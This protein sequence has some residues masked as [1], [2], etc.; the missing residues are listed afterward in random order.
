VANLCAHNASTTLWARRS[1]VV[2]G[3]NTSRENPRYLPGFELHQDL[4]ATD[5][6]D[7]AIASADVLVLGVASAGFPDTL[8][9][10]DASVRPGTP[11]VS[12]AK[13]LDRASARRMT[14]L[15]ADELPG[16]PVG[17]L[18]GPNLAKEVLSGHAA[19]TVLAFEDIDVARELQ[20]LF[21]TDLFR[22]YTNPDVVG[23]ELGGALKNVIAVAAGM[24]AGLGTGDN[25]MAA[26][27]TRGLA[28]LTRL[29]M[30]MGGDAQT[31]AGLAGMGDLVATCM[32]PQSRNRSVGVELGK[33]RALDDIIAS[34]GQVAEGVKSAPIVAAL[35]REHGVELPICE[36][37]RAVVEDGRSAE[38]AYRGLLRRPQQG[39]V[40]RRP[41]D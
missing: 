28:E 13:G 33:G 22:V 2:D 38:D 12:L 34:L 37:V 14:Q 11:I 3:I 18:S 4:Q 24:A 30:A 40:T 8:K 31:F 35:G 1:E 9:S 6:L 21:A 15:V 19:A 16:H 17:V 36:E 25:T 32:S 29:G 7:E 23:C 5:D 39:E 10:V 20:G 26:V 27:I 41:I